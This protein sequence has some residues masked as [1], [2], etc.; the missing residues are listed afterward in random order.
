[1]NSIEFQLSFARK[2]F[3]IVTTNHFVTIPNELSILFFIPFFLKIFLYSFNVK[4]FL[5]LHHISSFNPQK[6][7][8]TSL[9]ICECTKYAPTRSM[10]KLTGTLNPSP[11]IN[12]SELSP[13]PI[14]EPLLPA[15]IG[16]S[17]PQP[18][19]QNQ[20]S[21]SKPICKLQDPPMHQSYLDLI[22]SV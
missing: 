18:P 7:T 19:P 3:F 17:I 9:P 12:P 11:L 6:R 10:A 1:M 22:S 20:V 16:L 5:P 4:F 13:N 21:T 14:N 8:T 15:Q 2:A